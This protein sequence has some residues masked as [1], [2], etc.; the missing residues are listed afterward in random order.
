MNSFKNHILKLIKGT[1]GKII[2]PESFDSRILKASEM[3]A[4]DKIGT[5]ILPVKNIEELN[6]LRITASN[7]GIKLDDN[8]SVI[9]MNIDILDK[10]MVDNFFR[11][12]IKR[13][14]TINDT[15]KLLKNPL[16]F[17]MLYLKSKNCDTC[18]CGVNYNTAEVL[19]AGLY[20]IG[21]SKKI[22]K[23]S[24]Y[25]IMVPP[26]SHYLVKE[27]ILFADCAVNPD[28][29][30]LTLKDIALTTI[31]NFKKIFPNRKAN[32]AM[33][34]FSSK[35]SSNSKTLTKVIEA[36]KLIKQY[37]IE[38]NES[39]ISV[40]GEL[41]FDTAVV[42][43]IGKIK[44][45]N[46]KVAGKANIFIFPDLNSG[47]IG[48]KIAERYGNFKA[49]GPIVQGFSLPVSDLSRGSC[50]NDIYMTSAINLIK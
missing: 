31:K 46:S 43:S 33:L 4:K 45:P 35:G 50:V 36:T 17:S 7:L 49:F 11:N 12:M 42:P 41:Q 2:M 44:A 20:V 47:N 8:I 1:L 26:T 16:Y 10:N 37:L 9:I 25:F 6:K 48:Y 29:D 27:P 14:F 40:D 23:I 13:G 18:I 15:L 34:S 3:I 5:V 39:D 30:I 28:P 21:V 32:V 19:K 24:S 22:K 38:N